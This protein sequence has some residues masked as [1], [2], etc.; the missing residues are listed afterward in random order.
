MHFHKLS[1]NNSVRE[2]VHVLLFFISQFHENGPVD[3]IYSIRSSEDLRKTLTFE[4]R[5]IVTKTNVHII[6]C[7]RVPLIICGKDPNF[8]WPDHV[9]QTRIILRKIFTV[10]NI[11]Y[12]DKNWNNQVRFLFWYLNRKPN[13]RNLQYMRYIRSVT[14]CKEGKRIESCHLKTEIG[15]LATQPLTLHDKFL[16]NDYFLAISA[17]TSQKCS[18][19]YNGQRFPPIFRIVTDGISDGITL[20]DTVTMSASCV[21]G[22]GG[23]QSQCAAS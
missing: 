22:G 17:V 12:E 14:I 6:L 15:T 18:K 13:R 21:C 9:K 20:H 2:A 11:A 16:A 7:E 4:N 1:R 5:K 19:R 10:N 23:G 3:I 8:K